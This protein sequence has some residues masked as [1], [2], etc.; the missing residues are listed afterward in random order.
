MDTPEQPNPRSSR[1][2]PAFSLTIRPDRQPYCPL[3]GIAL[4]P[5]VTRIRTGVAACKPCTH[6]H[7]MDYLFVVLVYGTGLL[8]ESWTQTGGIRFWVPDRLEPYSIFHALKELRPI[9]EPVMIRDKPLVCIPSDPTA[10]YDHDA[11][12]TG[13]RNPF[14][15]PY[16]PALNHG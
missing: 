2:N 3:C 7:A 9:V 11:H 15:G 5:Q 16:A 6:K 10:D 4:Q 1:R 13:S 8:D 12:L 14:C